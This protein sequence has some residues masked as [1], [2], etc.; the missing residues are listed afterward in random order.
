[1]TTLADR[2]ITALR[3]THDDLAATV[4]GLAPD[5]LTGPSGATEWSVAQA[6]SHLGS[7][8]EITLANFRAA[9]GEEEAQDEGFNQRVWDRWNTMSPQEQATQSQ[10][11][12][13][14]LVE[15]LERLTPEQRADL[16][17]TVGFL[18]APLPVATFGAMRLNEAVLH[19]WDVKLAVDPQAVLPADS[20]AL[21]AEHFTGGLGFLLGFLG[22]ADALTDPAVVAFA[23]SD[24]GLT[25]GESVVATPTVTE[26]TATFSGPTESVIRLLSG[27]LTPA[28]T[29]ADV[30]VSGNV[31]LADLRRVFPG[32]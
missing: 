32:F 20:A 26:A 25:I 4:A 8:A 24:F 15:T 23:S 11:V 29:P 12:D 28:H 21:L 30:S 31:T 10:E 19:S 2:T 1:M 16:Q 5:Q 22:K 9:L 27:R 14:R 18:P 17:I 7:G 13:G 3:A 6:L